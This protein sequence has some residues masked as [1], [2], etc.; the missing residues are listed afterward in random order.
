M[1][2]AKAVEGLIQKL[3]TTRSP[4]V[5]KDI[6]VTLVRL[7]HR[8][9]DYDGS[10]W[11]IRPDTTGPYFDPRE[12]EKSKRIESVLK[13]AIADRD[14]ESVAFLRGELSRCR[15]RLAGVESGNVDGRRKAEEEIRVVLAKADPNNANQIGNMSYET[16]SQRALRG[17]G[18]AARGRALF[19]SQS[20][21]AC[22]TVADG[23]APK[24]PHLVDIGKRYGPAELVESILRPSAKIAQ[25]YEAYNFA[26]ADG[27]VVSGFVVTEGA[28]AVEVRE[29]SGA[30]H[31]LKR[32]LIEERRRQETSVMPEGLAT[33]LTPEQLS[34]LVA[35]LQ[36]LSPASAAEPER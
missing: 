23:Q 4:A 24:G 14:A 2:N 20:C 6:L 22:H 33:A 19:G 25:G 17:A 27:R 10:W 7:Y 28:A 1:H 13:A 5:R 18:D 21:R 16:A 29:S 12:W 3:S 32:A 31:E 15:V 35:Y 34:D 11:G 8:E 9:A 30:L 36:S 26:M